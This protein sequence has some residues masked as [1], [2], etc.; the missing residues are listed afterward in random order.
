MNAVQ[1]IAVAPFLGLQGGTK[2]VASAATPEPLVASSTPCKAVWIGARANNDGTAA[3]TSIVFIGGATVQ[4]IPIET[5]DFKG[6]VLSIDDAAKLYVRVVSDGD[7][8]FY[9]VLQ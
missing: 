8:V 3:N 5:S 6:I 7:G 4:N 1:Y 9:Q 2:T